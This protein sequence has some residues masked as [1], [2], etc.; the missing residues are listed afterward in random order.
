MESTKTHKAKNDPTSTGRPVDSDVDIERSVEKAETKNER[1]E[2]TQSE[3]KKQNAF[4][5]DFPDGGARAWSVAAGA[6]GVLF[7]TFGYINAFGVYQEYYQTHQLSHRTPSDISWIG[8]LQ[9]FFLFSGSAVGGPLFDRYGGRTIWPAALLYVF[10][11]MMTSLCKEYYQFMLTQGILG[12]VATGMTMAPGMT[13]VGQY[14]NKKRG[15]AMGITV[16]G[17]SVGGVIF[18]IALAKMFANPKLGFGWSVRIIGFIML[19]VLGISCTTIRARLPPRKKSFFLPA[20]FKELPYI[21]LL[22]SAFLMMLGVFIPIFYLPSYAVQ[23]G[24]STE[25]ASYLISILNGASFFG[26]VIPGILADKIGRLN[27]L[28]AVGVSTGILVF[29]WQSITSS[30]GIIVFAAIYGFCSG[31]IVSL[32]TLCLAMVPKNPQNIGTYMGM[33]MFVTAFAA[34]IGPPINGALVEHYH[35][36]DQVSDF[37]GVVVLVGGLFVLVIK[38][39]EGGILKRV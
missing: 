16:A 11:V 8:S 23:Y 13:A 35:S 33:G 30:A 15:A 6:A 5:M 7:C 17:S 31:A 18:P 22:V 9:V 34:L 36:F 25:L 3:A 27:M 10:S 26:R 21:T 19:A 2:A 1:L 39:V 37:S 38:F 24:M 29:C 28:C 14:F 4:I 20:A 32:V 12:G